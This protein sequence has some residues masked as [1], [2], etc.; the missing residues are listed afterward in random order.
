MEKR[1]KKTLILDRLFEAELFQN[2]L[3]GDAFVPLKNIICKHNMTIL[4]F[5]LRGVPNLNS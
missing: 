4:I 3:I 5:S 1:K 2:V